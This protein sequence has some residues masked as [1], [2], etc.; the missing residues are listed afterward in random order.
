MQLLESL[1]GGSTLWKNRKQRST[2]QSN[3]NLNY[4]A[5]IKSVSFLF[6]TVQPT[7]ILFYASSNKHFTSVELINGQIIYI[8][9]L[10]NTVNATN[11]HNSVTDG[12]WHNLTLHSH[13]RGLEILLDGDE[14][15]DE[16]DSAGVHDFLDPYLTYLSLGGANRNVYYASS[17]LPEP[18]EGCFT[19]FTINNEI[20]PFN[21]SGSIFGEVIFRG[22]VAKECNGPIGF[23]A[24]AAP[25]PLSI[26][27]TLV[28]VFFVVLLLA[29]LVSFLV[30]R[31]RKQSKEK[32]KT[33]ALRTK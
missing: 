8:S 33:T 11:S 19:N 15:S 13:S 23:G 16:L 3:S 14:L 26:G 5:P 20:Q 4:N 1:Y 2:I 29:I 17:L 28:I 27:I 30:F 18:F 32:G 21:G 31:I 6:R 22:K 10:A 12:Q 7:G 9:R 24:T 25:D